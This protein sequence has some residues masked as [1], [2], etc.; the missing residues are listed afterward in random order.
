MINL[1]IPQKAASKPKMIFRMLAI[2]WQKR[3]FAVVGFFIGAVVQTVS[4][5]TSIYAT[6]QLAG[7]LAKYITGGDTS[8]IWFWL[9]VDVSSAIVTGLGFWF[10]SYCKRLIY[11]RITAWCTNEFFRAL[12]FID[13]PDFYDKEVRNK[14]NKAANGYSWQIP[15]LVD[16]SLD[17]MFAFIRFGAIA[18]IVAQISWWLIPVIALF[19]VPSLI[20]E[21]K[22]SREQWH[23]WDEKGDNRYVFWKLDWILNQ[24]FGQQEIRAMQAGKYIRDKIRRMNS[25]F[26]AK[27]ELKYRYISRFTVPAK[28]FEALSVA[29]GSIILL[30]QFLAGSILFE[31]YLFL[32]GGL[33][34]IVSELNGIFGTLTRLQE[35]ILF[36]ENFLEIID[37]KP[38]HLDKPN[39]VKLPAK[40]SPEIEFKNVSFKYPGQENYVFENL[41]LLIS[42]DDH[43]AIVGENGAGKS[44]L[45]KLLMR[46]YAPD[47]GK[48]L[49]NGVDLEDVAI[50]SWYQ[51]IASL[52]QT[53]NNYPFPIDENIEIARPEYAGDKARLLQAA[54]Y[55]G[56]A[57]MVDGLEFG[58]DTVL[59][60]SFKKGTEPSGGQWQ[61]VALARAFY[62]QAG[63]LILDEPTSA[64]DAKAEYD[65][66]NNI[67]EAYKNRTAIIISHRFSTVR[68]ANRIIVLDRG[69]VVEVG[70]HAQLLKNQALYYEMFSKQA[71]GYK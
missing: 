34:R 36:A 30:K 58:W 10:M 68:R 37:I 6:A 23:V 49:I 40:V 45:I 67:F 53:F 63:L 29:V 32:S 5:I 41:N 3:P 48:I 22:I 4:S 64:I 38:T 66:F 31:K 12:C 62:R 18:L 2:A 33:V 57:K 20:N 47:S 50:A 56:V 21:T 52:F 8:K 26:Y 44:T 16:V 27:Q 11:Y 42:S 25:N 69:K 54:D 39:A 51:N 14:I 71:E 9:V 15:N 24:P 60:A 7:L 55:A 61:R 13:M 65:I 17:L 1:Q 19:L 46:F 43:V 35:P 70:S 28:I 59:D